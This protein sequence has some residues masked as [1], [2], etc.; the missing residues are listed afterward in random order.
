MIISQYIQIP[1][2]FIAHLRPIQL[3]FNKK[4]K[5]YMGQASILCIFM[6]CFNFSI[7]IDKIGFLKNKNSYKRKRKLNIEK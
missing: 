4:T 7:L 5:E 2:N 1:N 6:K 3:Y